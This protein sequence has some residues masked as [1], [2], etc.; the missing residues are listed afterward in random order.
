MSNDS[1]GCSISLTGI[2]T[3]PCRS[4]DL[5]AW[6]TSQPFIF[7]GRFH[8]VNMAGIELRSRRRLDILFWYFC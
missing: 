3:Y 8:V 4:N 1:I 2:W 5:A 6:R 7:T